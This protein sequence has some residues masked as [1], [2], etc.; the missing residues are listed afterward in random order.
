MVESRTLI[1]IP[2]RL[3]ELFPR[4]DDLVP[5][6][7]SPCATED[8]ATH[9]SRIVETACAEFSATA[10]DETGLEIAVARLLRLLDRVDVHDIPADDATSQEQE[11]LDLVPGLA[12]GDAPGGPADRLVIPRI[13]A[14]RILRE[15][16]MVWTT[17]VRCRT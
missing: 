13:E 14:R 1:H 6:A 7:S 12:E 3:I 4:D 15:A 11:L 17:R 10:P 5:L 9:P 8:E 16:L 2:E